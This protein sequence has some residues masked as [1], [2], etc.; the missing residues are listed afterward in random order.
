MNS[1]RYFAAIPRFTALA[2]SFASALCL[3]AGAPQ[4][5]Q[6]QTADPLKKLLEAK[7]VSKPNQANATNANNPNPPKSSPNQTAPTKTVQQKSSKVKPAPLAL[8]SLTAQ[9]APPGCGCSF[10]QVTNLK[11]AGPLQLR[12][13]TD[14]KAAIKPAGSV[15]AMKV[16][17]EKHVRRSEK[18]VSAKDKMLVKLRALEGDTSASLVSTAERNC[19]KV[20][21]NPLQCVKVT[22][23]S[24][25]TFSTKGETRSYPMWG[26]CSCPAK[27]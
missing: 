18:T 12:F 2:L 10:Y 19:E 9:E 26:S 4:F 8:A 5:A 7:P 25:L 27:K 6:A 16:I 20:N 21:N 11:D 13:T 24:L 22:Y 15:V 14:G 23:Q 17:E 3:F 1:Y